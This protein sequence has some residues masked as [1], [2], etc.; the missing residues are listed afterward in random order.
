MRRSS[1]PGRDSFTGPL[2]SWLG[3]PHSAP[4]FWISGGGDGRLMQQF[5]AADCSCDLVDY[6]AQTVSGVQKRGGTMADLPAS[7]RFNWITC[8]HMLEHVAD[9]LQIVQTLSCH[10][11]EDSVLYIEVP[12]EIWGRAPLQ[13][14]PV[15]H[16]NFF[17]PASLRHLQQRAGLAVPVVRLGSYLHPSGGEPAHG[18]RYCPAWP[19]VR[20]PNASRGYG[21]PTVS[22]SRAS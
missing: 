16:V 11:A 6:A 13:E 4:E 20:K 8:S 12:M 1:S 17:T 2:Q 18:S 5:L 10:L 22:Q 7:E 21:D 19:L 9:P 15:T 14:E 3:R